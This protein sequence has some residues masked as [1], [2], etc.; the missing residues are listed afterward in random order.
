MADK[1]LYNSFVEALTGSGSSTAPLA[2]FKIAAKRSKHSARFA[3]RIQKNAEIADELIEVIK[4]VVRKQSGPEVDK[5]LDIVRDLL[6]NN[7]KLREQVGE[8]LQ[9]IPD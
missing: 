2:T 6:E 4:A 3:D 1:E 8:A 5:L 9:D 7:A